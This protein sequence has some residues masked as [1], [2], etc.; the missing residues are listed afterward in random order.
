MARVFLAIGAAALVAG[1]VVWQAG[2][3]GEDGREVSPIAVDV[4]EVK[5]E[6][7]NGTFLP[8]RRALKLPKESPPGDWRQIEDT[9]GAM[10]ANRAAVEI[11][12]TP[13]EGVRRI[14][15]TRIEFKRTSLVHPPVA[16]V[17]YRPCKRSLIGP[18]IY[19]NLDDSPLKALAPSDNAIG[20]GLRLRKPLKPVRFPW[21]LSLDRPVH[22]YVVVAPGVSY[23]KWSARLSWASGG[24]RG[25]IPITDHG[26]SFRITDSLGL[27]WWAPDQKGGWVGVKPIAE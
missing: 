8:G 27:S 10:A 24:R 9:P 16:S 1:A 11:T 25:V 19:V 7:L 21:T 15:L 13:R 6:C 17:F 23:Y 5:A 20:P 22:L 4:A 18:A 26:K 2:V 14:V 3:F 12:I